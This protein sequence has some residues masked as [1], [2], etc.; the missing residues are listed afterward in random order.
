MAASHN[1]AEIRVHIF[2][3][4]GLSLGDSF[5]GWRPSAYV[6]ISVDDYTWNKSEAVY[7]TTSCRWNFA[8]NVRC[9]SNDQ[10][11]IIC[12]KRVGKIG[13]VTHVGGCSFPIHEITRIDD[14]VELW[15][16]SQ[17]VVGSLRI[18]VERVSPMGGLPSGIGN[19]AQAVQHG[20]LQNRAT[21]TSFD[22]SAGIVN[23]CDTSVSSGGM[24]N[25]S[26]VPQHSG[27]LPNYSTS[28]QA[29]G[30]IMN[31]GASRD[32]GGGLVNHGG[33]AG[34][35][36]N[37]SS[38][39]GSTDMPSGGIYSARGS[40]QNLAEERGDGTRPNAVP[41]AKELLAGLAP[42]SPTN[43]EQRQRLGQALEELR[44]ASPHEMRS[45]EG[46][47]ICRVCADHIRAIFKHALS[48]HDEREA[49]GALWLA[50]RLPSLDDDASD[51]L[52]DSLRQEFHGFKMD[53]AF[54]VALAKVDAAVNDVG[55][56][57]E[58]MDALDLFEFH[59]NVADADV[60]P[61][62]GEILA[63]LQR[64]LASA[65]EQRMRAGTGLEE[66]ETT[67][68]VLGAARVDALS[69]RGVQEQL[70]MRTGVDL[71]RRVLTPLPGE[72]GF[73]E[74]K[75]RQLRHA[76]MTVRTA[77]AEHKFRTTT[78]PVRHLILDELLPTLMTQNLGSAVVAVHTAID[79]DVPPNDVWDSLRR[80][81]DAL[82]SRRRDEFGAMLTQECLARGRDP[83]AWLLSGDLATCRNAL[84][85]AL[86]SE[87]AG[88]IQEAC[89]RTM[90][91]DGAQEVCQ[92]E[93]SLCIDK[94]RTNFR[95]PP[96]WDVGSMLAAGQRKLLV[97]NE[98]TDKAIINAIDRMLK[99]T[100]HPEIRTRDRKGAVP[101][102][103]SAVGAVQVMN[104]ESWA[105]FVR[106]RDEIAAACQRGKVPYDD[107]YWNS[108][109]NGAVECSDQVEMITNFLSAPPLVKE[110]NEFWLLHGTSHAA[111]EGITTDVFD[112]SRANPSGLFGA[113]VYFGECMS[114]ADEY[115]EGKQVARYGG[116]ELYPLLLV[117]V[118]LGNVWY[119]D[120]RR[121]D[122]RQ[123]EGR[124][125][126][127]KW[128]SVVGDRKKT[129]GTFR[130]FIIYDNMQAFPA[131]IVYYAR[132]Y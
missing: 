36:T 102:S 122:R 86:A 111:A 131:Y 126:R 72:I 128:D 98:I 65:L 66:V 51:T 87:N 46:V 118:C 14:Q 97:K 23:Y 100:A 9:T 77:M 1:S 70:Q 35:L 112:M 4:T 20:G 83:P 19:H 106:R 42:F 78:S 59:A 116:R 101:K 15:N 124:C 21:T 47:D 31:R 54:N 44:R 38:G 93:M 114:K 62:T 39:T 88:K 3:A 107:A 33:F 26:A 2:E 129:S 32:L 90:E 79:L 11:L 99:S 113:G 43:T 25:H 80:F 91:V 121:P 69:L 61:R 123:L 40:M 18:L 68:A 76:V 81:V 58:L 63:R 48:K 115:V 108:S 5:L 28:S 120:E 73:S 22:S 94:L 34:G 12:V 74:M 85:D 49:N 10:L 55:A 132:Q 16:D 37:V 67:L 125:I 95:L 71:L 57:E 17:Q 41:R 45:R 96:G 89:Q 82:Q 92:H 127:D 29:P 117:R 53:G 109:Y 52:Q 13:G 84:V 75:K 110:A 50:G 56:L 119:C 60:R 104:A 30:S 105:S 64:P 7:G 103:F 27:G 8:S 130:E 24:V 6:T